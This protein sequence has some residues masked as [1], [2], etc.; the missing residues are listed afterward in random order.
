MG[1]RVTYH[2]LPVRYPRDLA[3]ASSMGGAA[4]LTTFGKRMKDLE[5]GAADDHHLS[6]EVGKRLRAEARV[7]ES[8]RIDWRSS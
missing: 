5:N 3:A 6:A 2:F 7:V 4:T 8:R 1:A